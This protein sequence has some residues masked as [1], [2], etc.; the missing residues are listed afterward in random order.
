MVRGGLVQDCRVAEKSLAMQSVYA[1]SEEWCKGF[2][3]I[4]LFLH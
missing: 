3:R 2:L 4:E 1:G